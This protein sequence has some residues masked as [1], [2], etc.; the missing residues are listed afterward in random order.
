M[1]AATHSCRPRERLFIA[2]SAALALVGGGLVTAAS[3][4]T[5]DYTQGVTALNATQAQI[6]FKPTTASSLVDVHNLISGIPQQN[7][8]MADNGGTWQQTVSNLS[9]GT[10]I[11]YWFTYEKGGPLYDTPHFT[12]TQGSGGGGSGDYA[13]GVTQ[14]GSS[15]AQI[16]FKPTTASSLVDVHYLTGTLPQQDF[17]MADNGGTWQQTVSNLVSGQVI[18]YWFTYVKGGPL[19]DTGHFTYTQGGGGGGNQVATPVLNPGPG[20]YS[21][22]VSV[23]ITDATAGATIRYTLDG[24]TPTSSSPQYTG[25]ISITSTRTLRAIALASGM[26]ASAVAGGLYS[27]GSTGP[28]TFPVTFVNNTNGAY[29]NSQIYVTIL[30][31]G[32]PGQW[33]FLKPDSGGVWTHIDYTMINAP[34]HLTKNGVNYPNMS[35]TLAQA[36][37]VTFPNHVEGGRIYLSVGSPVYIPVSPDNAGWGGPDLLNPNDPNANVYFDWYELGYAYGQFGFGGNTTQVDQFGF[38]MTARLQQASTGY[39]STVG[40]TA[41]RASVLS[42]YQNAVGSAFKGLANQYRIVAPRTAASFHPGGANAGYLQ[43]VIDQFWSY[44]SAHQW[45]EVHDGRTFS[46]QVINGV[47]T[48]T[49]DD[50][51]AFSVPKPNTTNVFECS[52]PL[53]LP[54]SQGGSDTTREVGRDLCA[55]FNR[56]VGMTPASWYDASKYYLTNPKNDYAAYFHSISIGKR[57][58]AFAYD[59]VDDQSSVRILGNSNPPSLLTLG[60]GW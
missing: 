32:V 33:S 22:A 16:W 20:S 29:A 48:G 46:G 13:Q 23:T 4:A 25:A 26:T 53:A 60:I 47:L 59:D 8:R 49:K 37:T 42:G 14:L 6:W 52:G 21:A 55:A 17:R 57:S 19:Y 15:Q 54:N 41:T 40:I 45:S 3:A 35:F 38:P 36:S 10:V 51:S 28:G 30:G 11:E 5:G 31:M 2:V 1:L 12:Y 27:I 18:T 43:S 7:F 9:T 44:Y 24:S 56:G 39:D 50:G 58:Y 34:G